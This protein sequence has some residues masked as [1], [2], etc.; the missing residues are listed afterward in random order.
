[1]TTCNF[2]KKEPVANYQKVWVRWAMTKKGDYARTLDYQGASDLND[3]D[4][5][6]G[7]YNVHVCADHEELFLDGEIN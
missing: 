2:C 1:M 4:E 7:E 3:N 5:P 6:V